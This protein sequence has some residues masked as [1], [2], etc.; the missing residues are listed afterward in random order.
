MY[1]M[2]LQYPPWAVPHHWESLIQIMSELICKIIFTLRIFITLLFSCNKV[3]C[4]SKLGHRKVNLLT[5]GGSMYS[6]LSS[7][8]LVKKQPFNKLWSGK[9]GVERLLVKVCSEKVIPHKSTQKS[10]M[11]EYSEGIIT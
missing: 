7:L 11:F 1:Y 9:N 8:F 5:L 6:S 3:L 10:S 2:V 4:K